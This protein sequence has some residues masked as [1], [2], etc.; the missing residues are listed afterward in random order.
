MPLKREPN[1]RFTPEDLRN[2][3]QLK[4][5]SLALAIYNTIRETNPSVC[6]YTSKPEFINGKWEGLD[7]VGFDGNFDLLK[8]ADALFG[9]VS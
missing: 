5:E 9:R 7:N 2:F 3:R 6:I 4:V 8:I 1:V